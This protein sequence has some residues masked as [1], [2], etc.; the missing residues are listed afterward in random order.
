MEALRKK[1]KNILVA[2]DFSKNSDLAISRAVNIA[3]T[4]DAKLTIIHVVQKKSIDSFIDDS[5]KNLLPKALWLSTKEH[6][7]TLLEEK[8]NSLFKH[9]LEINSAL[10]TKGKP[11]IKILQFAKKNKFDLLIMGAHG[12]YSLRDTFVGTTAE[13][14]A[15]KTTCPVLIVKNK[16]KNQFRK[17]LVPTDFSKVSKKAL[18][19][20]SKLFPKSNF[21]LL[22]VGDYDFENLLVKEEKKLE[23]PQSKIIKLRKAILFDLTNKMKI[24]TKGYS[25]KL[26]KYFTDIVLGYPGPSIIKA[27]K[28]SNSDV[29]VMG[30]QGHGS[31]HYLFIGSVAQ[32]VL[33]DCDTD[34]LLV[35]PKT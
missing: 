10:I 32:W 25:K 19:Y 15:K 4:M 5:L 34:I 1:F 31:H 28:A 33:T 35:P 16:S 13:Y 6:R 17:I 20:A 12:K 9:G 22:H 27:A 30:T 7:T 18:D 2:T 26:G 14:V 29:I 3:K 21:R 24:F 8:I 23:I 11:A